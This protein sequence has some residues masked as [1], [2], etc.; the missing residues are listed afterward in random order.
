MWLAATRLDSVFP[1]L[2]KVLLDNSGPE[3]KGS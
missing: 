2:E 1:S 3:D